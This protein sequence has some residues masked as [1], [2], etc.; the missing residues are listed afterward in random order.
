M[1]IFFYVNIFLTF[2]IN[3]QYFYLFDNHF[4]TLF[5]FL[6]KCVEINVEMD[7]DMTKALADD[8]AVRRKCVIVKEEVA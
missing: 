5:V 6:S 3:C 2:D 7:G 1:L 8:S 4:I